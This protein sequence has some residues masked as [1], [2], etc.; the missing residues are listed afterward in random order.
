MEWCMRL[1]GSQH[2]QSEEMLYSS[3]CWATC[4][5]VNMVNLDVKKSWGTGVDACSGCFDTAVQG[6]LLEESMVPA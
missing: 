4:R 6:R 2:S 5:K 3:L 1:V